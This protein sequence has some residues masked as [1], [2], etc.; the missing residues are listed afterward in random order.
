MAIKVAINGFGRIGRLVFRTGWND[1][2]LE[3]VAVNNRSTPEATAL[4]LKY[5]SVHGPF[6]A[7]DIHAEGDYLVI[8]GRRVLKLTKNDPRECPWGDLGVDVVVESTGVFVT[9]EQVSWHLQAGAKKVLLSAP[10]KGKEPIK[11]IVL[12]VN[13]HEIDRANDRILSNASCTTNC[14]APVAKVLQDNYGIER[15]YMVTIHAYTNDQNIVDDTHR[16]PRRAR[17]AALNL[18]P[19]TSGAAK[20]VAEVIPQLHGKLGAEAIRA[21][22]P[23]GSLCYFVAT[24]GREVSRE[25]V[26]TLF[27]N[28]ANYH[29]KGVM[30]YSEDPLVSTDVINN[31]HSCIVDGLLTEANGRMLKVVAWYDN[32]YG[33]S[34]RMVDII[35]RML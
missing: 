23:D 2:A 9:K 6:P 29:L 22:V 19:T 33:Y 28:C 34:C 35:K 7:K 30:E 21:P 25:E 14:F 18:I 4:L 3:F 24:L 31:P 13:E 5:D 8:D 16:D 20:A 15:G 11:T 27:R 26:N 1:P 17:A 12:G 10:A 32:E